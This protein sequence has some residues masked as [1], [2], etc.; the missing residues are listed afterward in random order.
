MHAHKILALV[1]I[2]LFTVTA[3]ALGAAYMKLGD[4][5]GE[6]NAQ[7]EQQPQPSENLD[8]GTTQQP[9]G[10]LLPAIQKNRATATTDR[11]AAAENDSKN[12]KKGNIEYQWKVEKGE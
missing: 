8:S 12:K 2:I 3:S 6:A 7:A 1:T 10:L 11:E 9:T 5:K 4:I